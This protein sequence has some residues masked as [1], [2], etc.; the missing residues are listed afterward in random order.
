MPHVTGLYLIIST[1]GVK[2]RGYLWQISSLHFHH[3]FDA[4]GN[5]FRHLA[6]PS[7]FRDRDPICRLW[8]VVAVRI[9][10]YFLRVVFL[11]PYL[12]VV[13]I[14][15]VFTFTLQTFL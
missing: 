6:S 2:Q 5:W 9:P 12:H 13:S 15:G 11:N 8:F 14:K 1:A 7:V 10:R 3:R 4:I